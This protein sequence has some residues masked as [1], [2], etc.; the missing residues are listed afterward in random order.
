[1]PVTTR[2]QSNRILTA[3]SEKMN[4]DINYLRKVVSS[5]SKKEE[6][7][8]KNFNIDEPINTKAISYS[9]QCSNA[10]CDACLNK[11]RQFVSDIKDGLATVDKVFGK[12][13]KVNEVIKIFTII[14]S[15]FPKLI[16]DDTSTWIKFALVV[17]DKACE[18]ED[19][20]N[21]G[22]YID[23]K[24]ESINRLMELSSEMKTICG[25]YLVD[26]SYDYKFEK[27]NANASFEKLE[28]VR[29]R[30]NN[31]KNKSTRKLRN[32]K[33]VDYSYMDMPSEF[34][35]IDLTNN[36][37]K[38]GWGTSYRN[39]CDITDKYS[40]YENLDPDYVYEEDFD[41][42]DDDEL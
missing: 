9:F 19:S 22:E 3:V 18:F 29:Q 21:A 40:R 34:D 7:T 23:C 17:Y 4:Y 8:N 35:L 26:T 28:R 13:N 30:I 15:D 2:S 5:K 14:K 37:D 42:D 39:Y 16:E 20:Y 24:Q 32:V 1:M 41:D 10:N 33:K 38:Y 31:E 11:R 6:N 25:K 12:Q 36:F 27:G